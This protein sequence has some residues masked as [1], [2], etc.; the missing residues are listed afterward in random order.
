MPEA[1]T[2]FSNLTQLLHRSFAVAAAQDLDVIYQIKL[3]THEPGALDAY[4]LLV[5]AGELLVTRGTHESPHL[6][7]LF[8]DLASHIDVLTGRLDPMQAFL[9]NR[10]RADGHIVL[11]MRMLQLFVPQYATTGPEQ[12][13]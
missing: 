8:T 4:Y 10:L 2:D 9:T 5:R 1:N 7:L 11:A 3:G 12:L 13:R 6:T